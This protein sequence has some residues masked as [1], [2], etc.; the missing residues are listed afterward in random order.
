MLTLSM[1]ISSDKGCQNTRLIGSIA[2][3]TGRDSTE[4]GSEYRRAVPKNDARRCMP[5]ANHT[6]S[7][8]SFLPFHAVIMFLVDLLILRSS[9]YALHAV[10]MFSVN[11]LIFNDVLISFWFGPRTLHASRVPPNKGTNVC[12]SKNSSYGS[13]TFFCSHSVFSVLDADSEVDHSED[14]DDTAEPDVY[15]GPKI[16]FLRFDVSEVM[17]DPKEGLKDE[18]GDDASPKAGVGVGVYLR[19]ARGPVLATMS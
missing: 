2:E 12:Y 15:P 18:K 8:R 19:I 11:M 10:G 14:H 1:T 7:K 13:D 3:S 5:R 9:F 4:A 17:E 16:R 6:S